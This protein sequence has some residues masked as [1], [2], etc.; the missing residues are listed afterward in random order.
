MGGDRTLGNFVKAARV[1]K[2]YTQSKAAALAGI[3]RRHFA[4][5]ENGENV[6]VALLIQIAHA[7]D[8]TDIPIG[9]AVTLVQASTV[10]NMVLDIVEELNKLSE[11]LRD[12]GFSMALQSQNAMPDTRL[13]QEFVADVLSGVEAHGDELE[14][15]ARRLATDIPPGRR[16]SRTGKSAATGENVARRRRG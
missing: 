12:I 9:G 5:I 3:S 7:L 14:A 1:R 8:L 6:S 10:M 15:T 16:T 11:R 4:S 13:A 2:G